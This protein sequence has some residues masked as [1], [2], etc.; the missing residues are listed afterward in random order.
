MIE[1]LYVATVGGHPLR[2][3]ASP[4]DDGRPDFAW[5]A[6]DDLHTCIGLNRHQRAVFLRKLQG[7]PRDVLAQGA[8]RTVATA[9]GVLTIAPNFVADALSLHHDTKQVRRD[10]L[11]GL[12]GIM[13]FRQ[14]A[15]AECAEA[16]ICPL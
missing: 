1:P 12:C 7:A 10:Y 3:F 14:R 11:I 8:L 5:H 13:M 15:D 2:F 16:H 4:I 6:V 9:D